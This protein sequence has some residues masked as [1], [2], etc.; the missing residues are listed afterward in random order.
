M[1]TLSSLYKINLC[2]LDEKDLQGFIYGVSFNF[3]AIILCGAAIWP[4]S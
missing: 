3:L 2:Q 4:H 1:K